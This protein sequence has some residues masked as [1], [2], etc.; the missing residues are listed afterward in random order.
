MSLLLM[1]QDFLLYVVA[2]WGRTGARRGCGNS[3]MCWWPNPMSTRAL[4]TEHVPLTTYVNTEPEP[5]E[6]P[7]DKGI[8]G[9]E[10]FSLKASDH[11]IQHD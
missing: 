5:L 8:A 9:P 7:P 3:P 1:V 11:H 6:L 2:G 10:S 4:L